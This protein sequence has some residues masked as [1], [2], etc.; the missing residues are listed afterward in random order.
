MIGAGKKKKRRTRQ[1]STEAQKSPA[2]IFPNIYNKRLDAEQFSGQHHK[3]VNA[4]QGAEGNFNG[5]NIY[6][7]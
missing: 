3:C 1:G 4:V 7:K 5:A 6:I 2:P